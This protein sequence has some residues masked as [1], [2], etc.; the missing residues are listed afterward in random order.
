[1]RKSNF[2]VMATLAVACVVAAG[3]AAFARGPSSSD[4]S[5]SEPLRSGLCGPY[6][7]VTWWGSYDDAENWSD[8][9]LLR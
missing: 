3:P 4:A 7:S 2:A 6:P 1:M 9:R 5:M 8:R